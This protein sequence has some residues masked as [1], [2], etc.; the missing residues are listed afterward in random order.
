MNRQGR[1]VRDG[2]KGFSV[3]TIVTQPSAFDDLHR[4]LVEPAYTAATTVSPEA[5]RLKQLSHRFFVRLSRLKSMFRMDRNHVG[6][7]EAIG[8]ATDLLVASDD[9]AESQ[10]LHCVRVTSTEDASDAIIVRCSF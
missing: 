7:G 5:V 8:L 1:A 2:Y 6:T 10:L 9:A 4:Y 3:A